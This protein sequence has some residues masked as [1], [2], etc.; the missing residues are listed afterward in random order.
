MSSPY[1][2]PETGTERAVRSS[3]P[4]IFTPQQAADYLMTSDQ[5]VRRLIRMGQLRATKTGRLWRITED[6][7]LE[8]IGGQK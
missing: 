1:R 2:R 7:L 3:L 6:A 5:H 4:R 8:L